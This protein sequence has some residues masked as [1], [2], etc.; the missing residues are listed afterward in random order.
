MGSLVQYEYRSNRQN[1]YW[2]QL[3]VLL[4]FKFL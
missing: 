4:G 3:V 1:S 2:D